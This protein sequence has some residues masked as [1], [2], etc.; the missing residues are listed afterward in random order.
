MN[1][2]IWI[3]FIGSLIIFFL[4]YILGIMHGYTCRWTKE[5]IKWIFN[6]K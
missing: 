4:G 2:D 6:K 1:G 5:I 3:T